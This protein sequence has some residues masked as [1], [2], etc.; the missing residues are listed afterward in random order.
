MKKPKGL[1]NRKASFI[2]KK[3]QKDLTKEDII[4]QANK[5]KEY[6]N[7]KR[8]VVEMLRWGDREQHS[9][10]IG[11]YKTEKAAIENACE[12]MDC[13]GGKYDC[14]ITGFRGEEKFYR[15]KILYEERFQYIKIKK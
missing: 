8:Y 4:L 5:W 7:D 12:H 3:T 2:P 13:R 10:V 6:L 15:H 14:E 11:I 1:K 9:Y